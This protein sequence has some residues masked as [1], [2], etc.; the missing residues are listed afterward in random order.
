[1][2]YGT[3]QGDSDSPFLRFSVSTF[4]PLPAPLPRLPLFGLQ[5]SNLNSKVLWLSTRPSG[6]PFKQS[7]FP[8]DPRADLSNRLA[9]FYTLRLASK[10]F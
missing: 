4:L 8:P 3:I 5:T 1:M 2:T 7:G 6:W 9:C 10:V